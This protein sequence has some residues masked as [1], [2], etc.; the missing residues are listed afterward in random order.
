MQD[1]WIPEDLFLTLCPTRL[2][3][4]WF[5][6]FKTHYFWGFLLEVVS[7]EKWKVQ[8]MC[9][10]THLCKHMHLNAHRHMF[11]TCIMF[12]MMEKCQDK[13]EMPF[14]W[15]PSTD[16][17]LI[18]SL[19]P[20]PFQTDVLPTHLPLW[21]LHLHEQSSPGLCCTQRTLLG[22][23]QTTTARQVL[24]FHGGSPRGAPWSE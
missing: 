15:V 16:F 9:T 11:P 13:M 22:A 21:I 3:S 5:F 18:H 7:S 24:S 14:L 17:W 8:C 6:N 1:C 19:I 20:S 10:G 12:Q 4:V 2:T 23:Q